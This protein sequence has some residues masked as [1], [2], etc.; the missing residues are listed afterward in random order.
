MAFVQRPKYFQEWRRSSKTER[1][2]TS[3]PDPHSADVNSSL[4]DSDEPICDWM[5]DISYICS[6]E[7]SRNMWGALWEARD[8][9]SRGPQF[10]WTFTADWKEEANSARIY[11]TLGSRPRIAPDWVRGWPIKTV[12]VSSTM[13]IRR[14]SKLTPPPQPLGDPHRHHTADCRW[15]C[16]VKSHL[17]AWRWLPLTDG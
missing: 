5:C 2:K 17:P 1:I 4:V 7:H 15:G 8:T 12:G 13:K 16:G 14:T 11:C 10:W 6:A 9:S 3:H